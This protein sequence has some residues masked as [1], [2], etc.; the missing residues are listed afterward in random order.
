MDVTLKCACG[1]VK[2][3]AK[4]VDPKKGTRVICL[5]DDC[6]TYAWHLKNASAVLDENGGTDVFQLTP[7]QISIT[8]G[9]EH[10]HCLRL[11]PKGLMRWYATCCDTPVANTLRRPKVPFAGVPHTFMLP[12]SDMPAR[13]QALGPVLARVHARFG[14]GDL[15]QNAHPRAPVGLLFRTVFRLSLDWIAKKQKPSP[16]FTAE[17]APVTEPTVL[18][19]QERKT[20]AAAARAAA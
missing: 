12:A 15:P 4:D 11:S 20:A 9:S 3:I 10:I 1:A 19:E 2:G 17:G 8:E 18:T 5:C 7:S 13:D 16:F 14:H 6:Q